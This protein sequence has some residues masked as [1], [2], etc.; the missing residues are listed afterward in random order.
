MLAAGVFACSLVLLFLDNFLRDVISLFLGIVFFGNIVAN[1][2][3]VKAVDV[4]VLF[5]HFATTP[6]ASD[7]FNLG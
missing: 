6:Y 2:S 5:N 4:K 7:E 1:Y 3:S